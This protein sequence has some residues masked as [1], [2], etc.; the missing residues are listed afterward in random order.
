MATQEPRG[1]N[2]EDEIAR[3]EKHLVKDNHPPAPN[4][5]FSPLHYHEEPSTRH[6]GRERK[7]Q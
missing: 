5:P 4:R 6:I 7:S 3:L 1:I 2:L